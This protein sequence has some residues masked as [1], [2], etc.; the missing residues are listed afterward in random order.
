MFW[1]TGSIKVIIKKT[2]KNIL[3]QNKTQKMLKMST[4]FRQKKKKDEHTLVLVRFYNS[5]K[6]IVE[7]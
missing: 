1:L 5:Y 7:G 4:H 6:R 3:K 2:C